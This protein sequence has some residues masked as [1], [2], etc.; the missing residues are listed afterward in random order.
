MKEVG[1]DPEVVAREIAEKVRDLQGIS[2]GDIAAK[3]ML[4]NKKEVHAKVSMT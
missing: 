4:L 3:A 2:P 1:Q